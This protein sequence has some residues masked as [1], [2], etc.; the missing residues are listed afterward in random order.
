MDAR[1]QTEIVF[2]EYCPKGTKQCSV[3]WKCL[4]YANFKEK[5]K[6]EHCRTCSIPWEEKTPEEYQIHFL[7]RLEFSDNWKAGMRMHGF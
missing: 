7:E 4:P 2:S 1:E 3:C 5:N 6:D